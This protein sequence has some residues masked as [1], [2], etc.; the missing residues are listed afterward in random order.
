LCGIAG[1][2]LWAFPALH[3]LGMVHRIAGFAAIIIQVVHLARHWKW[4]VSSARRYLPLG[5]VRQEQPR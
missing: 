2:L 3:A 1:I 4:I 5:L